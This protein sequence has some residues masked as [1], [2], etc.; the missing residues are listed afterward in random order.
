[1]SGLH[2]KPQQVL[3][4]HPSA[5]VASPWRVF[6]VGTTHAEQFAGS[7]LHS[8]G[9]VPDSCFPMEQLLLT[10]G[11]VPGFELLA[12]PQA[13]SCHRPCRAECGSLKGSWAHRSPLGCL[14]LRPHSGHTATWHVPGFGAKP[15]LFM[16]EISPFLFYASQE[17]SEE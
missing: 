15:K 4:E 1:M 13:E 6:V 5:P 8:Q 2:A 10:S 3:V 14:A 9:T 16:Q 7:S 11:E 17:G 12:A